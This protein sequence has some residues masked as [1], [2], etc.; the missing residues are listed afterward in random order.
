MP[1][2]LRPE[3][4]PVVP[5]D[6]SVSDRMLDEVEPGVLPDLPMSERVFDE[7]E[8]IVL[9]DLPVS[10]RMLDEVEP[11]VLPDLPMSERVFDEVEPIVLP[12]LP[13]S[14]RMSDEV[15]PVV[16]PDLFML[17]DLFMPSDFAPGVRVASLALS[18]M[19]D[20]GRWGD[21]VPCAKARC[22]NAAETAAATMADLV[23]IVM[24]SFGWTRPVGGGRVDRPCPRSAF[25]G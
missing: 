6:L 25:R 22:A 15:E 24:F 18:D 21:W 9:P 23:F 3:V 20:G 13:V 17:S 19:L 14:D 5:P 1:A 4:E 2:P 16:P 7:V 12:D 10:D 8:P 11:V